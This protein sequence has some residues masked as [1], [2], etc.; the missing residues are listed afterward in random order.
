[1]RHF[2]I[3]HVASNYLATHDVDGEQ[4]RESLGTIGKGA[5]RL[6]AVIE[7]NQQ[8]LQDT[9]KEA[10]PSREEAAA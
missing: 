8:D 9:E 10:S 6:I 3:D 4:L 2:G 1:M 7:G 5:K